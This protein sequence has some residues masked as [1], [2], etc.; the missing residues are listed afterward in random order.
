MCVAQD[1]P[2]SLPATC[3]PRTVLPNKS[4]DDFYL[5]PNWFGTYRAGLSPVTAYGTNHKC[6]KKKENLSR[7]TS[8]TL[9]ILFWG[10][11]KAAT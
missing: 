5:A 1:R 6:R 8:G 4:T 3:I 7:I 2:Q 11:T 10:V 9:L